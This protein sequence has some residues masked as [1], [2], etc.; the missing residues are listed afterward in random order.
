ML[1]IK[2]KACDNASFSILKNT[3]SYINC[4]CSVAKL[5]D[6]FLSHG[7]QHARLP[8]PSLFPGVLFTQTYVDC[9]SDAI[10]PSHTLLPSSPP[11]FNLSQR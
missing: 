1:L 6:S 10:L 9:V 8:C 5:S 4:C 3:I 2:E 7:Q 11:A